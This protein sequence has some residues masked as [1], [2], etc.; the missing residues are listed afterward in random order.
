MAKLY[1]H[2]SVAEQNSVDLSWCLLEDECFVDLQRAIYQTPQE[3][4]RFRQLVVNAVMATD[5]ADKDLKTL[6][7]QRWDR[8]FN[9]DR[10]KVFLVL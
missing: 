3:K 1:K 4:L 9:L 2:R 5:I 10:A 7:N 8:A 6:R